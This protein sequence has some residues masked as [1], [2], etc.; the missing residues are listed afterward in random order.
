ALFPQ[1]NG[2]LAALPLGEALDALSIPVG[3][4]EAVQPP[5]DTPEDIEEP[6]EQPRATSV[7]ERVPYRLSQALEGLFMPPAEFERMLAI[8]RQKKNLVLQGAPGVGKSF[9]APRLAYSL[10]GYEDPSRVRMVQF[11]QSYSYEDFVQ[12]FR[13]TQD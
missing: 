1:L 7:Y 10:I 2:T 13:P 12:G 9:L 8:W 6:A 11:H 4:D 5:E 3:A